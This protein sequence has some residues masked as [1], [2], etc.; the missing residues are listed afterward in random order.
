MRLCVVRALEAV[1]L[2]FEPDPEVHL[3]TALEDALV[4]V[5]YVHPRYKQLFD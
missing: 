4:D 1:H 2:G 3:R 5:P